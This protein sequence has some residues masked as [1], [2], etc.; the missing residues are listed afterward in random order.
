M[1]VDTYLNPLFT[2]LLISFVFVY[3]CTKHFTNFEMNRVYN[4]NVKK[5]DCC[6]FFFFVLHDISIL[7]NKILFKKK[8]FFLSVKS[9]IL[10]FLRG[11]EKYVYF[12]IQEHLNFF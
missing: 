9:F 1:Y 11:L 7:K 6:N 12:F 8:E 3:F 4:R 10:I 5:I 2:R